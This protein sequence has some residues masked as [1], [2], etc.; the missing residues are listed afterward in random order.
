VARAH[1]ALGLT[2]TDDAG[3]EPALREAITAR[4]PSVIHVAVD[5]AWR[6]VDDTPLSEP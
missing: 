5:R 6:S 4:R 2:V 3:F 1:G